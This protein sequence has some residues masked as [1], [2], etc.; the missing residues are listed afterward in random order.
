MN[1]LQVEQLSVLYGKTMILPKL[2]LTV[3]AEKIT[4]IIGP[5]GC[6]KSTLLKAMG[7]II[8]PLHDKIYLRGKE[9]Q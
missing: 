8:K 4:T 3:A 2:N 9:L 1:I 6:G 5:N 7:R